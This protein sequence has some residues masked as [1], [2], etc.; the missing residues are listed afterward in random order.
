MNEKTNNVPHLRDAARLAPQ[1]AGSVIDGEVIMRTAVDTVEGDGTLTSTASIMNSKPDRAIEIQQR[2]GWIEYF[3]FDCLFYKGED[4]RNK[5]CE[6]RRG[7]AEK[8]CSSINAAA[9]YELYHLVPQF[10]GTADEKKKFHQ[11]ILDRG[12]EG[13]IC[14]QIGCRYGEANSWIK[15][16]R[17]QQYDVFITGF[18]YGKKGGKYENQIGAFLCSVYDGDQVVEVCKVVPGDDSLRLDATRNFDKYRGMVL[19]VEGQETTQKNNRIRHPRVVLLNR[20]DK[21]QEDCLYDQFLSE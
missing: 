10:K 15:N 20:Q 13:T 5:P 14:K 3:V 17:A 16:K 9:G 1:F 19:V 12:G 18:E 11:D 6:V 4:I 8:I 21:G 2:N 7:F